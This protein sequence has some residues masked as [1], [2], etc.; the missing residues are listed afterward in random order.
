[1]VFRREN[2]VDSFQRQMTALRQ[3]LGNQPESELDII[4]NDMPELQDD[5]YENNTNYPVADDAGDDGEYSFGTYPQQDAVSSFASDDVAPP[6]M[7]AL[8]AVDNRITVVAAGT[9]WKGEVDS[10]TSIHVHGRVNGTLNAAE[11]IWIAQGAVVEATLTAQRIIIAGTVSGS[12]TARDRFEALPQ[13]QVDAAINAP[14]FVVHE[15][16]VLNGQLQMRGNES[17]GGSR[18]RSSASTII[19]RRTRTGS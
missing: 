9:I 16:A 7:P 1:M 19:Q 6:E 3:Q 5:R 17:N 13:G 14:T 8:P 11:D 4:E 18:D 2:K 12:V 10:E 15:G